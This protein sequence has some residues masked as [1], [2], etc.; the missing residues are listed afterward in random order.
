MRVEAD[1]GLMGIRYTGRVVTVTRWGG[2]VKGQEERKEKNV[3]V[4]PLDVLSLPLTI[5]P[6]ERLRLV[7]RSLDSAN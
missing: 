4:S 7:I 5:V 2:E 3:I 1:E 6:L